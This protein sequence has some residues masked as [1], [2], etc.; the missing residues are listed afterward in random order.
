[1]RSAFVAAMEDV[2]ALYTRPRDPDR[3]LV[4][5][6]RDLKATPRRDARADPDETGTAQPVAITS[7]SAT[8]PPTSCPNF[9]LEPDSV[10]AAGDDHGGCV[11]FADMGEA[12][13]E[14]DRAELTCELLQ[15]RLDR[16][17]GNSRGAGAAK[18]EMGVRGRGRI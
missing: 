14:S 2:L 18:H 6:G 16:I 12:D 5:P 11:I 9:F 4:L 15:R 7:T 3:P 10:V 1:M 17:V 13:P 8:A